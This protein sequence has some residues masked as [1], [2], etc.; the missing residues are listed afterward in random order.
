MTMSVDI[1]CSKKE[2][3]SKIFLNVCLHSPSHSQPPPLAR[4]ATAAVYERA[5]RISSFCGTV[6]SSQPA[7]PVREESEDT[8]G[9]TDSLIMRKKGREGE[10]KE[11][12]LVK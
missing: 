11:E 4:L 6:F 5:S 10:N 3:F 8:D 2:K 1:F 7:P 12:I 9:R